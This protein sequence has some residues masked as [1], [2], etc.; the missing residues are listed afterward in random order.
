MLQSDQEDCLI[1]LTKA[2][3]NT[4]G[5]ITTRTSPAYSSQSQGGVERAH[6]TLFGQIRQMLQSYNRTITM[7]HPIMPWIVRHSAYIVNRYAI[8][9]NGFTSLY[10]RWHKEQH[11]PLCQFGETVQHMVLSI[12]Q[13]PKLEPRFFNGIW[14]GKDTTT[15]ESLIGI[16]NKI[17]CTY[18]TTTDQTAQVQPTTLRR[19]QHGTVEYTSIGAYYADSADNNHAN[20]AAITTTTTADG[21]ATPGRNNEHIIRW[22]AQHRR[23]KGRRLAKETAENT[24]THIAD[25]NGAT[26]DTTTSTANACIINK[27][28]PD[29]VT[30]GSTSKQQKTTAGAPTTGEQPQSKMRIN[31]MTVTTRDGKHVEKT[32]NEDPQEIENERILLEPILQSTEGLDP[33][34]VATGMKKEKQ[35]PNIVESTWMIYCSWENRGK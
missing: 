34:K 11:T 10:N 7:K 31:A 29:E 19:D 27:T 28:T 5:K 18:H 3:A 17:T 15:G 26:Y 14:L 12:K 13:F 21:K 32:S 1:A 35:W 24:A 30:E 25:G 9:A 8:H 23:T 2:V 16:Y 20:N 4:M 22:R 6:R 33:T